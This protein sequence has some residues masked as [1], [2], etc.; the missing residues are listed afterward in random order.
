MFLILLLFL[1]H[2]LFMLLFLFFLLPALPVLPVPP[3]LP[4]LPFVPVLF[5]SVA[6]VP[7][8]LSCS[9]ADHVV[10]ALFLLFLLL[11]C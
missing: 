7:G 6:V 5:L 4:V 10:P 1:L 3:A 8:F 9:A 11:P 2:F